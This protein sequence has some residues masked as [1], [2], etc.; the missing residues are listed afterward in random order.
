[1]DFKWVKHTLTSDDNLLGLLL[2]RQT[3]NQCSNFF[4]SL[5]LSQLTETLL[6]CP[7]TC[8]NNLEEQ[9]T[10]SGIENEDCSIDWLCSQVTFKGLVNSN[11]VDVGIIN[12]PYDLIAEE[13]SIVLRVKVWF[14]RFT[15]VQLQALSDTFSQYI[16]SRIGLHDFIHSLL[17][18]LLASQEP[19]SKT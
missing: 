10:S 5:P 4:S 18:Q 2:N 7:H 8:V 11:S 13:L 9:L 3:S 14:S 12:E 15:T 1:M 16:Q 19:I 17:D 6:T